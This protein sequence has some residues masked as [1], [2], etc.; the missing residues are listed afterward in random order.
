MALSTLGSLAKLTRSGSRTF[1]SHTLPSM[2]RGLLNQVL[3]L[4]G[5]R[6]IALFWAHKI[7]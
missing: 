1:E 2:F 7:I 6:D 4:Q 3:D 5:R